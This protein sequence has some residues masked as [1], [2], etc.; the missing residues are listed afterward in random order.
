[1]NASGQQKIKTFRID[2]IS[3]LTPTDEKFKKISEM[4]EKNGGKPIG[5]SILNDLNTRQDDLQT[6]VETKRAEARGL[7]CADDCEQLEKLAS[8][9]EGFENELGKIK[10]EKKTIMKDINFVIES[11][12]DAQGAYSHWNSTSGGASRAVRFQA[13]VNKSNK[14]LAEYDKEEKQ[15]RTDKK[16]KKKDALESQKSKRRKTTDVITI[17]E[18]EEQA[19]EEFT[20]EQAKEARKEDKAAT[21]ANFTPAVPNDQGRKTK[22]LSKASEKPT[23]EAGKDGSGLFT[24]SSIDK[25]IKENNLNKNH[26]EWKAC[27]PAQYYG[28]NREPLGR[29]KCMCCNEYQK[30][31]KSLDRHVNSANHKKK[32]K[33]DVERNNAKDNKMAYRQTSI[34]TS[35]KNTLPSLEDDLKHCR[36]DGIR[37]AASA[38]I[39]LTELADLEDSDWLK[40]WGHLEYNLGDENNLARDIT[41]I[42][43]EEDLA[44]IRDILG[45]KQHVAT[46]YVGTGNSRSSRRK[47]KKRQGLNYQH[48]S[49][50]FDG[51][52]SFAEAEVSTIFY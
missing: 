31:R 29:L 17:D 8:V 1:M 11:R 26:F 45:G 4:L 36:M 30:W 23:Y 40:N 21:D 9:L 16:Q 49:L 47:Y 50:I 6:K 38:N 44:T 5:V 3:K 14:L 41:H 25:V 32:A 43:H 48:F 39:T 7:K 33:A 10:E 15:K 34:D 46:E 22:P 13:I 2:N 28:K 35:L 42:V 18:E 52:P 27:E 20:I 51:T 12:R 19:Q 24:K 37:A